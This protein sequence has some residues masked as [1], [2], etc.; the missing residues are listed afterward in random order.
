MSR[1]DLY[2]H[3]A[4]LRKSTEELQIGWQE[5][6]ELWDDAVSRSFCERH[7]EPLGPAVKLSL[8]AISRMQ[9]LLKQIQ[10]E[11]ES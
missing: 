4:R 6:Q 1:W 3:A 7:L 2:T 9:Q 11:C 5:T 10:Q 8:D